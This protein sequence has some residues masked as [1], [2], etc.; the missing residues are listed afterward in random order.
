VEKTAAFIER[1]MTSSGGLFYASLDADS[2]GTEGAFYAWKPEEISACTGS[3]SELVAGYYTCTAPGN[4]ENGWNVLRRSLS[5]HDFAAKH[6]LSADDLTRIVQT[7]NRRLF[8][9][10]NNRIRPATDDKILT[11]W[12]ALMISALTEAARAFNHPLW[13]EKAVTAARFYR[14]GLEVRNEKLWRNSKSGGFFIAGF[15]DDYCFLIKAFLD[16]YQA[17]FDQSW[18]EAA[19]RLTQKVLRHFNAAGGLFFTLTSDEEPRLISETV[20]LTDNVIPASNSQMA[21]NLFLLGHLLHNDDYLKRSEKMVQSMIPLIQRN[22]AFHANWA[23]LLMN[24]ITGPREVTI[25]GDEKPA[26]LQEF[27]GYYLPGVIY[28]GNSSSSGGKTLITV[29]TGKTCHAPVETVHEAV[30]LLE[31]GLKKRALL[32]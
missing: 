20:E 18:L 7:A 23:G 1:E 11:C 21:M 27:A 16:L 17:T 12:N 31:F 13:L 32:R 2:E 24:F 19:D 5:D 22:P 26:R 28:R 4:W 25:A 8:E 29:C 6:G 15:L 30:K 3:D 10:R 14:D 9:A